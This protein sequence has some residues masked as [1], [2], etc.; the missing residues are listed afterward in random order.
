MIRTFCL[1]VGLT[2]SLA[3]AAV[4]FDVSVTTTTGGDITKANRGDTVSFQIRGML[5][6]PSNNEGLAAFSV[7]LRMTGPDEVNLGSAATVTEG[8]AVMDNFSRNEGYDNMFGG[9]PNNNDLVQ[10]GGASNSIDNDPLA[11][12]FLPFPGDGGIVPLD[13]GHSEVVLAAGTVIMPM[14]TGT[15][16]LT[17]SQVLA[18]VISM[19]E[20]GPIFATE[21]AVA[22]T[23]TPLTINVFLCLGDVNEDGVIDPLDVGFILSRFGCP[24]GTGDPE[25]DKA[26]VNNDGLVDPLDM[27][28]VLARFGSCPE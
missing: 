14:T 3:T 25:C 2:A 12:P 1:V 19:G 20:R 15:Y 18:N 17:V 13:V 6:S 26:D 28:F 11:D 4:T 9:T 27:G 24:V 21:M 8:D 5:D 22:G 23:I 10:I 16:T 7:D